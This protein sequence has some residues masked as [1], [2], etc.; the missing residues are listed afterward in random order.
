MRQEVSLRSKQLILLTAQASSS[1]AHQE[2]VSNTRLLRARRFSTDLLTTLG[3]SDTDAH[4]H[5][6]QRPQ[7]HRHSVSRLSPHKSQQLLQS[8]LI[9]SNNAD[10]INNLQE[11]S[12]NNLQ[13]MYIYEDSDSTLG[14]SI[15]DSRESLESYLRKSLNESSSDNSIYQP[16]SNG[17]EFNRADNLEY[18]QLLRERLVRL[19]SFP[20]SQMNNNGAGSHN[21]KRIHGPNSLVKSPLYLDEHDLLRPTIS[22]PPLEAGKLML[23]QPGQTIVAI[24]TQSILHNRRSSQEQRFILPPKVDLNSTELH[25]FRA[26]FPLAGGTENQMRQI[27]LERLI[28]TLNCTCTDGSIDTKLNWIINESPLDSRDVRFYPTRVS[29]DHRQTW[30]TVGLQLVQNHPNIEHSTLQSI[31]SQY[32]KTT[33]SLPSLSSK[34][35]QLD[36]RAGPRPVINNSN[37]QQQPDVN[38]HIKFICQAIHSMLLYSSSEMITFDFNPPPTLPIDGNSIDKFTSSSSNNVIQATSGKF[39]ET[40]IL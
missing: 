14:S 4:V 3:S 15:I 9:S 22:W 34:L 16:L 28:Q 2:Q 40:Q 39:S 1:S 35:L 30:I 29:P 5:H 37:Q 6:R 11:D 12:K 20:T 7:H 10:L 23:L 21:L 24:P 32:I 33:D 27:M 13:M 8:K 18:I 26:K 17:Y 31:L 36:S 38:S 19:K 25:S